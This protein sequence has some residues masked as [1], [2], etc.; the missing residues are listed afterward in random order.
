MII[1]KLEPF[2]FAVSVWT[3]DQVIL[4]RSGLKESKENFLDLK[5]NDRCGIGRHRKVFNRFFS[6]CP[7]GTV[8]EISKTTGKY[9][10][11]KGLPLGSD[12]SE[13]GSDECASGNCVSPGEAS[14]PICVPDCLFGIAR[15]ANIEQKISWSNS[16]FCFCGIDVKNNNEIK[17]CN[18]SNSDTHCNPNFREGHPVAC[19]QYR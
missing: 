8:C 3:R 18:R 11:Q 17:I 12:C 7:G 6:Y 4:D 10:C 13:E 2:L 9:T 15:S 16:N 5:V 14:T 1:I 19:E